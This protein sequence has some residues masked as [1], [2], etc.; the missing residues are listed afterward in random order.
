MFSM[1]IIEHDVGILFAHSP[2]YVGRVARSP[3]TSDYLFS[4]RNRGGADYENRLRVRISPSPPAHRSPFRNASTPSTLRNSDRDRIALLS[5]RHDASNWAG[6]Q[7]VPQFLP[8]DVF[9]VSAII[10]W[11]GYAIF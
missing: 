9:I 8:I 2:L 7:V 1:N 11:G 3:P 4:E 5:G 6:P 10:I